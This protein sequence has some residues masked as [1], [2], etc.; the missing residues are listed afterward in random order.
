MTGRTNEWPSGTC[1]VGDWSPKA[2]NGGEKNCGN[3]CFE[4]VHFGANI[5]TLYCIIIGFRG[6]GGGLRGKNLVFNVSALLLAD[7]LLKFFH[8]FL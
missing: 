1:N 6:G 5:L 7:T 4:M 3:F 2:T 8:F